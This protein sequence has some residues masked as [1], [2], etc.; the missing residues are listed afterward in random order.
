MT[1][2]T[3][4]NAETTDSNAFCDVFSDALSALAVSGSLLI[5]EAYAPPWRVLIPSAERFHAL[6]GLERGAR[7]V[8]FHYVKRGCAQLTPEGGEPLLA[9]AGELVI[10]FGG[11]AHTLAQG[12]A[13]TAI[14]AEA[15]LAGAANPFRPDAGSLAVSTALVCG[16]FIVRHSE[17]N[18]LFASLPPMLH[19][20]L[21]RRQPNL[22]VLLN[23]LDQE[24]GGDRRGG[25]FVV[26]RLLELLCA[27]SLRSHLETTV[28]NGW[29]AGLKDPV[30]GRAI[31]L[32]HAKPGEDWSVPRLAQNVAMSPSRLAARFAAALQ[33]SPMA[34]LAKWRMNLAGRMLKESRL[35][36]EQIATQVGYENVA[37]FTRS[38]KRHLGVTPTIWRDFP[39]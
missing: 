17:L 2:T 8:A 24:I 11:A 29:L 1:E 21:T 12:A 35:S 27:E 10:G 16:M 31:A 13:G 28:P 30:V 18:P 38:F 6:M 20:P 32:M 4:N 15:L 14:N 3:L 19:V 23:W 5:N 7:V 33:D 25:A 26:G 9:V 34:Y 39:S 37:A 36:V 22:A